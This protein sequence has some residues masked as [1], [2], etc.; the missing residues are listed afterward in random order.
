[1]GFHNES[2]SSRAGDVDVDQDVSA[3]SSDLTAY[4]M[5]FAPFHVF[6]G[7][8]RPKF[9]YTFDHSFGNL[10][11]PTMKSETNSD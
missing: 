8:F 5:P 9:R 3:D 6:V 4:L 1:M 10:C 2:S 7:S 11:V